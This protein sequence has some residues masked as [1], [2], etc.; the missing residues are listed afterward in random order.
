MSG[1]SQIFE[2]ATRVERAHAGACERIVFCVCIFDVIAC[3]RARESQLISPQAFDGATMRVSLQVF[4][5]D[6]PRYSCS[7]TMRSGRLL[8]EDGLDLGAAWTWP[9]G[10]R[11]VKELAMQQ[12]LKYFS[13]H[14][15]GD[16]L[17]LMS[18]S[19]GPRRIPGRGDGSIRFQK[20]TQGIP[21][22]LATELSHVKLKVLRAVWLCR[23][24]D[25]LPG[26]AR[27][28]ALYHNVATPSSTDDTKQG[29]QS[30]SWAGQ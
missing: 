13:Q 12:G 19:D 8:S 27:C 14:A 10:E 9:H 21:I 26:K 11:L 29:I 18:I 5:E 23:T 6:M 22:S 16:A 7:S 20:G 30:D 25:C 2:H 24:T 1:G 17:A 15:K 4:E 28:E 3:V